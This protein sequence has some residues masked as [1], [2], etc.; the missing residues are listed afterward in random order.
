MQEL[1]EVM[2]YLAAARIFGIRPGLQRIKA[3]LAELGNPQDS[4][5][6]VHVAGTNGKGSVTAFLAAIAAISGRRTG[7]Y[8]SPYLENFNERIRLLDGKKGFDSFIEQARSA[9]ITDAQLIEVVNEVRAA[10]QRILD[11]GYEAATEFE[12][13]TAT[14]FLFYAKQDCDMVI[15]E[16]GMG[17]R[18]DA[19]NVV[20][21]PLVTVITALGYDHQDRLGEHLAEIAGEKS[22]IMKLSCPVVVLDPRL[23]RDDR[24]EAMLAL[25]VLRQVARAKNCPFEEINASSVEF[26]TAKLT[27]FKQSFYYKGD[28]KPYE[29][30]LLAEY[31]VYN[32]ALAIAAAEHF[33]NES[34][35]REG[36]RLARWPGRF[37]FLA[38]DPAILIDGAHNLQGVLALRN[39]LERYFADQELLFFTGI[40][41]DKEHKSMLKAVFTDTTYKARAIFVAP[42]PVDRAFE[43][44]KL[45]EE[46]SSFIPGSEVIKFTSLDSLGTDCPSDKRCQIYY[47]NDYREICPKLPAIAKRCQLPLVAFGSLYLIG[48]SRPLLR[49]ALK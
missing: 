28:T 10:E 36:L 44:V 14:A 19:T 37:E 4:Y 46:I 45:A 26:A 23:V 49:E 13:I 40:L 38:K 42:P 41:A 5:E 39:E 24:G 6:V 12:L 30:S 29:I 34:Q 22:G 25:D 33:A 18:L 16:T 47:V 17:G 35:I 11:A 2:D 8:T 31:Q 48:N 32:A 15:L 20:K 9:E 1:S 27:E 43:A 3:L 7:W 21:K